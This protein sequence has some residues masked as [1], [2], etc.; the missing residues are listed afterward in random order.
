MTLNSL[1]HAY[2]SYYLPK[3]KNQK[4]RK[5]IAFDMGT[6]V[7]TMMSNYDKFELR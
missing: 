3:A 6:S 1:R 5:K 7:E 2:V 4:E